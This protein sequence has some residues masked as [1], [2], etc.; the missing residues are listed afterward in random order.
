MTISRGRV[1]VCQKIALLKEHSPDE[2]VDAV[3]NDRYV[4][5]EPVRAT[6]RPRTMAQAESRAARCAAQ[7]DER[8]IMTDRRHAK[9]FPVR[10]KGRP[11]WL[12]W[13]A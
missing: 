4:V 13:R 2:G 11:L 6:P 1:P 3:K 10:A 8:Q 7:V 12:S 5:L 9:K